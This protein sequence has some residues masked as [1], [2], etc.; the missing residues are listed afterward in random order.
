MMESF[1]GRMQVQQL[2]LHP[3]PEALWAWAY[4]ASVDTSGVS[5]GV[6]YPN[7]PI[8]AEP[9]VMWSAPRAVQGLEGRASGPSPARH[10]H[11]LCGCCVVQFELLWRE[12]SE[13]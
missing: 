3:P 8:A 6:F 7:N 2:D 4:P 10:L 1:W 5:V 11:R 9:V 12:V 13:G